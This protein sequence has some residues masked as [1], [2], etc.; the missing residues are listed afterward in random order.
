MPYKHITI[1][2]REK[3]A[4]MLAEGKKQKEIAFELS[5]H[6]STIS[7]EI[8]RNKGKTGYRILKAQ[9]N[10]NKRR[11]ESKYPYKMIDSVINAYVKSTLCLYWSSVKA[12]NRHGE[13]PC[14]TLTVDRG[15]E[16]AAH[17][18]LEKKLQ[19]NVYFAKPYQAWQRGLNENTNGLLRQF[20]PKG[21]DFSKIEFLVA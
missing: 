14:H 19:C 12:L 10:A 2:E 20:L 15:K 4:I 21:T 9:R 16:F 5:R 8:Q 3:I 13:L 18:Q 11:K 7:R 6:K 17:A 1:N